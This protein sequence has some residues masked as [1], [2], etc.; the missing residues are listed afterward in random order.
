[1]AGFAI[2]DS[3]KSLS[4]GK[5]HVSAESTTLKFMLKHRIK[6]LELQLVHAL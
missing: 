6:P 4:E 2:A 1:M 5:A 3:R